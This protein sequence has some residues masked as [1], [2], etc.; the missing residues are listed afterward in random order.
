MDLRN[1]ICH[2]LCWHPG[3][4]LSPEA[5]KNSLEPF[6]NPR[7]GSSNRVRVVGGGQLAQLQ[8]RGCSGQ[9]TLVLSS[10]PEGQALWRI[11]GIGLQHNPQTD[12][13][14]DDEP[15]DSGLL[16]SNSLSVPLER[17]YMTMVWGDR[18]P[19]EV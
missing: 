17:G 18:G 15:D 5:A 7:S 14:L 16:C 3:S 12:T 1:N 2:G 6:Q 11:L 13:G 19:S 10:Q 8:S 4:C 9:G